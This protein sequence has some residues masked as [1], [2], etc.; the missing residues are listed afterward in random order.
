MQKPA[1]GA[2]GLERA[3][4]VGRDAETAALDAALG[5][6]AAFKAPQAVTIVGPLGVGKT[7]LCD[8]WL[9][10]KRGAGLRVTR[11]AAP[12][13]EEGD[14]PAP[15]ALIAE[16]LRHRFGIDAAV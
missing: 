9:A 8:E 7:R 4:F 2:R 15:R 6:A 16:L 13:L 14:S 10:S 12:V 1:R 5:R 3:K 11:A